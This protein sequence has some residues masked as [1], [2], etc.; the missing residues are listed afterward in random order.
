MAG[1]FELPLGRLVM[2]F[3]AIED[4]LGL[5]ISVLISKDHRIGATVARPLNFDARLHVFDALVR[6]RIT[7]PQK[8]TDHETLMRDLRSLQQKRNSLIHGAWFDLAN[9]NI[10]E[11][12]G[13]LKQPR[14]TLN[15]G[16]QEGQ[17]ENVTPEQIAVEF[18]FAEAL[19]ELLRRAIKG[20]T[21]SDEKG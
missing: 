8:I 10:D 13:K 17:M 5:G 1:Q 18:K 12:K 21:P 11:V 9:T 7:D 19:F 14:L 4:L 6:L 2:T 20:Y 15:K 3:G 16:Y